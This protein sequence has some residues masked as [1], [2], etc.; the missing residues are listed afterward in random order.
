MQDQSI[1]YYSHGK[2][3]ISG[4]YL[5]LDGATG[6]AIPTGKGQRLDVSAN[7]SGILHFKSY[8]PDGNLWF[9]TCLDLEALLHSILKEDPNPEP[10]VLSGDKGPV[11]ITLLK[12]LTSINRQHPA[13]LGSLKGAQTSS[14]LEF[15]RDW[16]LGSSST[17]IS[18][19]ALWSKTNPYQLLED[20]LGGSGY[21]IACALAEGPL[22][23]TRNASGIQVDRAHFDPAF[24]QQLYFIHLNRKQDSREGIKSYKNLES[25]P[26]EAIREASRISLELTQATSLEAFSKLIISHEQ[27]ISDLLGIPTVREELFP[28]FKGALKSLG[29]WGG[30]FIL[31]AA[32]ENPEAYFKEKGYDTIIPYAKMIF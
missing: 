6:L 27:I 25:T 29:A 8:E 11:T 16:G 30:D 7:A 17:F 15:P 9:E 4:E 22:F 19:M 18:N 20:S 10:I 1:S 28:D 2:L 21:D 32:P 24:K 26:Q 5:I 3:L 31:A 23:Y 14:F 12:I 13:F